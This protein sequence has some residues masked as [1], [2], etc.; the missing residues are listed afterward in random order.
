MTDELPKYEYSALVIGIPGY[1]RR[2]EGAVKKL[3]AYVRENHGIDLRLDWSYLDRSEIRGSITLPRT[4]DRGRDLYFIDGQADIEVAQN[5][6]LSEQ[7][8]E[9]HPSAILVGM[10]AMG[11]FLQQPARKSLKELYDLAIDSQTMNE[12]DI[13]G[14]LEELKLIPSRRL[15]EE[16]L[17]EK[18]QRFF[19][20][21][22]DGI[23]EDSRT[24]KHAIRDG[25]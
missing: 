12:R 18:R 15:T 6:V 21:Y 24:R 11:M 9:L 25:W 13:V 8:R 19:D 5:K 23:I 4:L 17:E 14:I 3:N 2:F 20:E 7:L 10:S 22:L 1:E 16:E